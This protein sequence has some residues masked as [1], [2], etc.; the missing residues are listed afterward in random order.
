[1][2]LSTILPL[3]ITFV[4]LADAGTPRLYS[5]LD[6]ALLTCTTYIGKFGTVCASSGG[7]RGG[8]NWN[9]YC[10]QDAG[11]GTLADCFVTG[12]KNNTEKIDLF[13]NQCNSTVDEFFARYNEVQHEFEVN[14]TQ[15]AQMTTSTGSSSGG[16]RGG[17][18]GRGGGGSSQEEQVLTTPLRLN[19]KEPFVPYR[20]GYGMY[21]N[22]YRRSLNYGAIMLG[23]WGCILV[24]AIGLNMFTKVFPKT[25]SKTT[26]KPVNFFKKY[27]FLPATF[28]KKKSQEFTLGFG[29]FFDGL[30]PSRIETVI[31]VVFILLTGFV[32]ALHIHHVKD[33]PQ[34]TSINAELGHFIADRTGITVCY[35]IPLLILFGGRNNFMQWLTGW[36][37]ATFLMYHRWISRISVLLVI[38]HSIA[39]TV[40][41]K[42]SGRYNTRM[43]SNFMIWG[44]VGTIA[45][46][47]ILFQAML[48]FRRRFYEV[49]FVI[50][51]TL[52]TLFVVG[53]WYHLDPMGYGNF[54]WASIAIWVFDR[55]V[56]IGRIILFGVPKAEVTIKANETLKI[57][58]P[59][60]KYWHPT[61]GGHAFIYFIRP[62][63]FWQ[64]HPFTFT[65]NESKDKIIFYS[66]IKNGITQRI[67]KGLYNAPGQTGHI[68]VLV[69]GPYGGPSG[70]G[71]RCDNLVFIAGGNG[72]PGIYSEC[73]DVAKRAKNQSIKL[74][75]VVRNWK[76]LAWFREELEYLKKTSINTTIYVTKPSDASGLE[77]FESP[78]SLE[79]DV[80]SA[81]KSEEDDEKK[82]A[83][84]SSDSSRESLISVIKETF[85]NVEFVEG[86]PNIEQQTKKDI[87]QAN[88][89][90]A[91]ITCGHAAMVD[92]IRYA[93]KENL[94]ETKYNV[95]FHEKLQNWS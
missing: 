14:N 22:N 68:R 60:P 87:Q 31:I 47:F 76:S 58:I 66:K 2:K 67:V 56:R 81:D 48:F 33:N 71:K 16:G 25:Y 79:K 35:L 39:F 74:V 27:I 95:E 88:G 26:G 49:F 21:Y 85:A 77:C 51:I 13:V 69:E 91:F 9:C 30:I 65:V 52:A 43:K 62:F 29:G 11:F 53:G 6:I 20:E 1:M 57:V 4:V 18:G 28:S 82:L 73:V 8:T 12:F 89:P 78:I 45:G 86:R 59:K 38:V 32:N 83:T 90:I 5:Q 84:C 3:F 44:T 36:D 40:S 93:V 50:H 61:P 54:M 94:N 75:W 15:Y 64:S 10:H 55:V 24:L 17:R 7:R 92:E 70:A 72:I 41:D 80:N 42:A 19:Y 34:Y 23:Y 46:S 63:Q 37:F